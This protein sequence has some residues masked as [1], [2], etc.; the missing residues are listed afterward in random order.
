VGST[1]AWKLIG[2]FDGLT[3]GWVAGRQ[4]VFL[5]LT[6]KVGLHRLHKPKIL[7]TDR[8]VGLKET[9]ESYSIKNASPIPLKGFEFFR[10]I[11][12]NQYGGV[13]AVP[14]WH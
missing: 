9:I 10:G 1:V 12:D 4:I 8:L 5:Q 3:D 11:K 13:E 6:V 14:N 7:I 2:S